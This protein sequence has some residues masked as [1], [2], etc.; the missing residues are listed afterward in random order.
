MEQPKGKAPMIRLGLAGE[1]RVIS[2]LL[3][4]NLSPSKTIVD[5]GIDLI[6]EN[7]KTIQVKAAHR[8]DAGGRGY[9]FT[10]DRNKRV[11]N[12]L[13]TDYYIFWLIDDDKFLIVPREKMNGQVDIRLL[14]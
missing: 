9:K 1:H 2:E 6:L 11:G 7:G 12:K 5:E 8:S 4:R 3:L 13:I 10:L 14:T